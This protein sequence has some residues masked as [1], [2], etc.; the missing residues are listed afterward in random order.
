MTQ[1]DR[2]EAPIET[3][4]SSLDRKRLLAVA[5]V[6]I[7]GIATFVWF[8]NR[9]EDPVAE[10]SEEQDFAEVVFEQSNFSIELPGHWQFFEQQN[11]DPQIAMVAGAPGTQ[12]N[13]RVRVSPL[14]EPVFITSSTPSDVIAELQAEFDKFIDDG[15]D[16][17]EVLRRQRV[18]IGSVQGWQYLYTFRDSVTGVEGVHSHI[19]LLG[20][21][22]LYVLV[23]QALPT[24]NFAE[25]AGTFDQIVASFKLLNEPSPAAGG[26][27]PEAEPEAAP[28]P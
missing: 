9:S 10:D 13:V 27:S 5:V 3:K 15:P 6:V 25:L 16:V 28:A 8:S 7:V 2:E 20:G 1:E 17:V 22:R 23:F 21:P 18:R 26:P 24:E 11:P 14:A 4:S 12:N 19:F